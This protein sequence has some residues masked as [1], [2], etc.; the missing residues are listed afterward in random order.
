MIDR[1]LIVNGCRLYPGELWASLVEKLV[2]DGALSSRSAHTSSV[3]TFLGTLRIQDKTTSD[4]NIEK[5]G[6]LELLHRLS[7]MPDGDVV[8]VEELASD[9]F[10]VRC[11]FQGRGSTLLGCT[12][13]ARPQ[14]VMRTPPNWD[15][16]LEALESFNK[17][18]ED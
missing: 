4:A 3:S 6:F 18:T 11:V 1:S 2:T 8:K 17:P 10:L 16:S 13:V 7:T 5:W 12:V 14:K 9:E 15:G